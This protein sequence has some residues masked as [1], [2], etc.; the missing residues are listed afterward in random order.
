MTITGKA[1]QQDGIMTREQLEA[2]V[3]RQLTRPG[4]TRLAAAVDAVLSAADDYATA[5]CAIAVGTP[6]MPRLQSARR[7]VL[8]GATAPARYGDGTV[9]WRKPGSAH[10]TAVCH[11]K[12]TS[13]AVTSDRS[14][15]TCGTCRQS[16]AWQA[17]DVAS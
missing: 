12:R 15:V 5:Q 17:L 13:A 8:E 4:K 16:R 2:V 14:A 1:K 10:H 11:G 7:A 9:H 3:W 6:D